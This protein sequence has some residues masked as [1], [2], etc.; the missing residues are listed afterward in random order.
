MSITI[1]DA[2]YAVLDGARIVGAVRDGIRGANK[3][4]GLEAWQSISD[5]SLE[6]A[7]KNFNEALKMLA[8][9]AHLDYEPVRISDYSLLRERTPFENDLAKEEAPETDTASTDS[10]A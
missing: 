5:V 10:E 9:E 3:P 2:Y 7:V 6:Y 8:K 1:G 4:G